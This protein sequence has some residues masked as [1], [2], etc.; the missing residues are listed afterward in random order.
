MIP[1]ASKASGL[2]QEARTIGFG[3]FI[4]LFVGANFKYHDGDIKEAEG[5]VAFGLVAISCGGVAFGD[6]GNE[7]KLPEP[8][9]KRKRK[10]NA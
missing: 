5:E 3:S 6:F 1:K 9:A 7:R 2:K 10:I 4:S 8:A